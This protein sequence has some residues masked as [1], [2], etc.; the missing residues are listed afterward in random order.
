MTRDEN[1]APILEL[2]DSMTE[3]EDHL[4]YIF[5]LRQGVKFHNGKVMTSADVVASFDRY[6]KVG[7][8]RNTLDDVDEMG[9]AGPGDLRHP[10]EEAGS[11]P[12]RATELVQRADHHHPGRAQGRPG[13][14]AWSRSGQGRSSTSS[15][16]P[17]A[18]SS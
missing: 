11:R 16:S 3:A 15:S 10:Y 1:N 13:A 18:T 7:L 9:R 6:A 4:S 14:P 8:E 17:T 12:H 5:K 2:A